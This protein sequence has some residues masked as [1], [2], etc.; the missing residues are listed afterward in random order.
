M[1][2][3]T[4]EARTRLR[5]LLRKDGLNI[6]FMQRSF[7]WKA[8]NVGEFMDYVFDDIDKSEIYMGRVIVLYDQDNE[9][10]YVM[11]GQQRLVT[12]TTYVAS[13]AIAFPD[14][15]T[16]RDIVN[17]F[18][19]KVKSN[20]PRLISSYVNDNADLKAIITGNVPRNNG[21]ISQAHR[22]CMG[23]IARRCNTSASALAEVEALINKILF[24]VVVVRDAE[25]AARIFE[26]INTKGERLTNYQRVKMM[27][28]T[29]IANEPDERKQAIH[30]RMEA[31]NATA[32]P[33]NRSN[34]SN[35][36]LTGRL[37]VTCSEMLQDHIGDRACDNEIVSMRKLMACH[38]NNEYDT[39]VKCLD[40]C[41]KMINALIKIESWPEGM[42]MM[43]Y[44]S[45]DAINGLIA[46]VVEKFDIDG[47]DEDDFKDL[48]KVLAAHCVRCVTR[49]RQANSV[50]RM[51]NELIDLLQHA[52]SVW[53]GRL[54]L[55]DY[56]VAVKT[57][58]R[59]ANKEPSDVVAHKIATTELPRLLASAML[60]F[61]EDRVDD[62]VDGV[63][64][65]S[66]HMRPNIR[67]DVIGTYL[68]A[69]ETSAKQAKKQKHNDEFFKRASIGAAGRI[70]RKSAMI[71]GLMES[72]SDD[73]MPAPEGAAS[74]RW[75]VKRQAEA[76]DV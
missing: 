64:I 50:S 70:E 74:E 6:P 28:M 3:Y 12:L 62:G 61:V 35:K 73:E 27:C 60:W 22:Q 59:A 37:L 18:A 30:D 55:N 41:N 32:L 48:V 26:V 76:M 66:T 14:N 46:P 16:I 58:L 20:E 49:P 33:Y 21:M 23:I 69:S 47:D 13:V 34:G 5:D 43:G 45:W 1:E 63:R 11:D 53:E 51:S 9:T 8:D 52:H 57:G 68:L 15:E 19:L 44:L 25:N 38:H 2:T 10:R 65:G 24:D 67:S 54:T 71:L 75:V 4:V 31:I 40:M 36:S 56:V 39:L 17:K 29:A 42:T 7:S 72:S